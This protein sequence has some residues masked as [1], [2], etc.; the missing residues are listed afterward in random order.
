MLESILL[1]EVGNQLEVQAGISGP[2]LEEL[3]LHSLS[4]KQEKPNYVPVRLRALLTA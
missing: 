2:A 4:W 1:T 3:G